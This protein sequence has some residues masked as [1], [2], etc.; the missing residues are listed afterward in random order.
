MGIVRDY[1]HHVPMV[2]KAQVKDVKV[3]VRMDVKVDVPMVVRKPVA[4]VVEEIVKGHVGMLVPMI[5]VV[6]ARQVACLIVGTTA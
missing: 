6:Y 5:V 1:A 4:E 3:V 2:V